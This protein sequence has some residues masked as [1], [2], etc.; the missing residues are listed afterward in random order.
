MG[1]PIAIAIY[2]LVRLDY[3]LRE[4]TAALWTLVHQ[5]GKLAGPR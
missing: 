3:L 5:V 4:Q 1:F 2:L